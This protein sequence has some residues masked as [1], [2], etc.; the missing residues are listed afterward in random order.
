MVDLDELNRRNKNAPPNYNGAKK[1]DKVKRQ[2]TT[3]LTSSR[4]EP[5]D[6]RPPAG[7]ADRDGY[8]K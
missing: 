8:G 4:D 3:W 7:R 6:S 2:Y 5:T 1:K